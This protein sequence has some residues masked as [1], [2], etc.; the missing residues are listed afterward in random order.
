MDL[1]L[2]SDGHL[3]MDQLMPEFDGIEPLSPVNMQAVRS[4][5][6]MAARESA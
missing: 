3:H 1:A 2:L 6:Q 4:S 5:S